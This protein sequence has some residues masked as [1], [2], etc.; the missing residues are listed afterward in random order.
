MLDVI[1]KSILNGKNNPRMHVYALDL[2]STIPV[3]RQ[4]VVYISHG[5]KLGSVEPAG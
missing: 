5:E 2:P 4:A 3:I 1:T